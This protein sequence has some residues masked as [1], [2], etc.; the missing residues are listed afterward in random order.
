[1]T[2]KIT[3]AIIVNDNYNK[4]RVD[5]AVKALKKIYKN[6]SE[7]ITITWWPG[8][9]NN[10]YNDENRIGLLFQFIVTDKKVVGTIFSTTMVVVLY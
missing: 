9:N 1:M 10:I 7:F 4:K 5:E 3:V 8:D 2:I 6:I